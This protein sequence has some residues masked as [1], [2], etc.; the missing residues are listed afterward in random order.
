M[1][2][3]AAS[4]S[5]N[6]TVLERT[7][8]HSS[9]LETSGAAA[10]VMSQDE[11]CIIRSFVPFPPLHVRMTCAIHWR[12]DL[13]FIGVKFGC[14]SV[15][16]EDYPPRKGKGLCHTHMCMMAAID[17]S[18]CGK[19]NEWLNGYHSGGSHVSAELCTV[20]GAMH[21]F[22]LWSFLRSDSSLCTHSSSSS[23]EV[24]VQPSSCTGSWDMPGLL[25][26]FLNH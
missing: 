11:S 14:M 17:H 23:E 9:G 22:S 4:V 15:V 3:M 1:H 21:M 13:A 19:G 16:H 25:R 26:H 5:N 2:L 20:V 10:P 6:Q 18:A 12:L 8:V 7:G 24:R